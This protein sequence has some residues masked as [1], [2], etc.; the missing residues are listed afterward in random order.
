M[1]VEMDDEVVAHA[2]D[3]GKRALTAEFCPNPS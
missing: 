2:M 1:D 3:I